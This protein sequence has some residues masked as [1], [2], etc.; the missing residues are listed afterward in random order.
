[1]TI[2]TSA[3]IAATATAGLALGALIVGA[4]ATPAFAAPSATIAVTGGTLVTLPGNDGFNDSTNYTVTSDQQLAV[5]VALYRGSTLVESITT[6]TALGEGSGAFTTTVGFD[7]G[8][9]PAGTYTVRASASEDETV[10]D[11]TPLTVGSGVATKTTIALSTRDLY[12]YPDNYKD[13]VVVSVTSRDETGTTLPIR[14]TITAAAGAT[15]RVSFDTGA[16]GT[17]KRTVHIDGLKPGSATISTAVYGPAGGMGRAS[18]KLTLKS[19]KL[20]GVSLS[21]SESTV[22]PSKDGYLDTTKITVSAKSTTGKTVSTRGTVTITHKGTTVASWKVGSS[23]AKTLTW[24]GKKKGKVVA[25]TYTVT[26]KLTGP[27][28]TAV[29]K[30]TSITVSA[31]KLESRTTSAWKDADDVLE[32]YLA[33]DYYGDGYCGTDSGSVLCYGYDTYYG[34]G[35]SIFS[36]GYLKVPSDVRASAR[37]RTP[38]IRLTTDVDDL[39]GS[40]A[41]G[42]SN[43]E[44]A[45]KTGTLRTGE[46][47]LGWLK[48]DKGEK[49]TLVSIGLG[50][51]SDL[52]L[53]RFKV[54]YKYYVLR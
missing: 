52:K 28:G 36:Y 38:T 1:M 48:L 37:Y 51:S 35:L 30:K 7:L 6:G 9:I 16:A 33:L 27:E 24:N 10:T 15:S 40:A 53:D 23:K 11:D 49:K 14:G 42:Y 2:S 13:D 46:H 39:S 50:D 8:S 32:S 21:R 22:Y 26:A 45:G 29:T 18:T 25:G 19:T 41:W 17:V 54:E 4:G 20:T 12:P 34:D 43:P 3:R 5:D 44:G 47:K 31:R